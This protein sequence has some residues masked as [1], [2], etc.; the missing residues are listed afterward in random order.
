MAN[1]QHEVEAYV[2][3]IVFPATKEELINGLLARNAPG[4]MVELV[5]RLARDNYDSVEALRS[6]L[7]EVSRVHTGEVASARSYDDFLAVVLLHVGD[8]RHVTKQTYNEVVSQVVRA[9]EEQ[10]TL[11]HA[12]AGAMREQLE[13]A[14]ADLR[15]AMTEVTDDA[16]PV[17]PR[18]DLPQ[19]RP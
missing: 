3:H 9:A 2:N 10:G 4:R 15:G 5:E 14:F 19:M 17:N 18:D 8:V 1:A 7:E 16:A 6:D 12:T 13:A 11:D